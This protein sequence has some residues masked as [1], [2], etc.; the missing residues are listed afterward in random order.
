[1]LWHTKTPWSRAGIKI[2]AALEP[3]LIRSRRECFSALPAKLNQAWI[4]LRQVS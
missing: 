4:D 1:L 3:N 2:K